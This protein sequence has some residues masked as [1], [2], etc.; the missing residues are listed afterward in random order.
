MR[1]EKKFGKHL[2]GRLPKVIVFCQMPKCISSQETHWQRY[3]A[4]S[5][6]FNQMSGCMESYL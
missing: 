3:T 6:K 1:F 4:Y 5:L 2:A